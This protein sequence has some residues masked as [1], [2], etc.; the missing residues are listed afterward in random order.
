MKKRTREREREKG[1]RRKGGLKKG[2]KK[3]KK[4]KI[5]GQVE[6][7]DFLEHFFHPP[8]C[9][10]FSHQLSIP[11]SPSFEALD[12]MKKKFISGL[13]QAIEKKQKKNTL[14]SFISCST[15]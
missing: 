2:K 7:L 4:E 9:S 12:N 1:K 15:Y 3:R 10:F 14:I 13:T 5:N 8:F 6:G 11:L